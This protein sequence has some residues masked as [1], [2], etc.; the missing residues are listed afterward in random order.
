MVQHIDLT[1]MMHL[2]LGG[3]SSVHD[4]LAVGGNLVFTRR[5]IQCLHD[6]LL[7]VYLPGRAPSKAWQDT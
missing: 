4:A 7:C 6:V 3:Y 5:A 1:A 2:T